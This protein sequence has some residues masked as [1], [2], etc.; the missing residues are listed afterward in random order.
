MRSHF[1]QWVVSGV[2]DKADDPVSLHAGFYQGAEP[3]DCEG[4]FRSNAMSLGGLAAEQKLCARLFSQSHPTG[5]GLRECSGK[6]AFAL[7][8]ALTNGVPHFDCGF[9]EALSLLP[10]LRIVGPRSNDQ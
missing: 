7:K 5:L 6:D 8:E 3:T 9:S 1:W 4:V 2:S 10:P